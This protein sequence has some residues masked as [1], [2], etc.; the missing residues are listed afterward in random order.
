MQLDAGLVRGGLVWS[1]VVSSG[2]AACLWLL[3]AQSSEFPARYGCNTKI[4]S[5]NTAFSR[6]GL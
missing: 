3:R 6:K 1:M 5:P 4:V 2:P